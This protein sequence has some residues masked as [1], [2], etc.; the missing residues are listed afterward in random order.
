MS[1]RVFLLKKVLPQHGSGAGV[2]GSQPTKRS[3]TK[4]GR[5]PSHFRST[6]D[7]PIMNRFTLTHAL[8][9]ALSITAAGTAGATEFGRVLSSRQVVQTVGVP[10]QVCST[11]PMLLDTAPTGGGAVAGAVV[12]G[13]AGHSIGGGGGQAIATLLGVLAGSVVGDQIEAS[14]PPRLYNVEHCSVQ[15]FTENRTVGWDVEYEYAGK[16]YSVR[17]PNDPGMRVPLDIAPAG[18]SP[19]AGSA[20]APVVT[21]PQPTYAQPLGTPPYPPS[22]YPGAPYAAAPSAVGYPVYAPQPV[23]AA[24]PVSIGLGFTY[25]GGRGRWR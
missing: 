1:F 17:L 13:L 16:Q 14:Q 20:A 15:N 23:Y 7:L 8:L 10:R 3:G 24:P 18:A 12:G 2:V 4:L 22:A 9:A 21:A 19:M 5:T 11:E 6:G 25:S